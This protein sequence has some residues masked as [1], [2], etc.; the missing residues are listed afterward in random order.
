LVDAQVQIGDIGS[1]GADERRPVKADNLPLAEQPR[2]LRRA[3]GRKQ[4]KPGYIVK[5]Q[6]SLPTGY[7]LIFDFRASKEWKSAEITAGDKNV[8]AVW[9]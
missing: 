3:R 7:L 5:D 6:N 8:A 1:P 9:V 4:A 2:A